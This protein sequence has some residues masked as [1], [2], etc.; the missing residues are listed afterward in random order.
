MSGYFARLL[1]HT[2]IGGGNSPSV[3]ADKTM[4]L[5]TE[6]AVTFLSQPEGPA[7]NSA[8]SQQLD[9]AEG[10][11]A[12]ATFLS[13]PEPLEPGET[14][15]I[16]RDT[17]YVADTVEPARAATPA[18]FAAP[19]ISEAGEKADGRSTSSQVDHENNGREN[20]D[21]GPRIDVL[22]QPVDSRVQTKAS[23]EPKP[24]VSKPEPADFGVARGTETDAT[25]RPIETPQEPTSTF[26]TITNGER[27]SAAPTPGFESKEE[28]VEAATAAIA[29]AAIPELPESR[30]VLSQFSVPHEPSTSRSLQSRSK[31]QTQAG[32]SVRIGSIQVDVHAA[33]TPDP[34]PDPVSDAPPPPARQP[35]LRRFY[36][37]RW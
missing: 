13:P 2:G 32:P 1:T 25:T 17:H 30:D 36:L 7:S 22:A 11:E 15:P 37:R 16:S 19:D 9:D 35:S 29:P 27:A 33:P 14:A 6:D 31:V 28:T 24:K 34:L 5:E 18:Q 12:G 10:E 4:P 8:V 3:E 23:T 21:R 20:V 26:R